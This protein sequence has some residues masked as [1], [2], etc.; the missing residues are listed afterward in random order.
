ML[1]KCTLCRE[2]NP[3]SQLVRNKKNRENTRQRKQSHTQ[4]NIFVVRQFAYV[5]GI[6]G[7]LLLS[8]KNTECGYSIFIPSKQQEDETLKTM[9]HYLE[10]GQVVNRIKHN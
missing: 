3:K 5:H 9:Q 2:F 7:I 6:A 10:S 8:G 4:D 1:G